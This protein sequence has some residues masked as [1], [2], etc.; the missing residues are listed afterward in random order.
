M[1]ICETPAS[2]LKR[3]SDAKGRSQQTNSWTP[4][5]QRLPGPLWR[6]S[7]RQQRQRSILG[8]RLHWK[9]DDCER[10]RA[11]SVGSWGEM[12]IRRRWRAAL[13]AEMQMRSSAFQ[14]CTRICRAWWRRSSCSSADGL[15][16]KFGGGWRSVVHACWLLALRCPK[17]WN[18]PGLGTTLG[19][20][21]VASIMPLV[22]S[23]WWVKC[24]STEGSR[25][26]QNGWRCALFTCEIH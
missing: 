14:G 1:S 5:P 12:L 2:A 24:W 21:C 6:G 8:R 17:A 9:F 11:A 3:L 19:T 22:F 15:E 20:R 7:M 13:T 18:R 26:I 25:M 16:V 4:G 23:K 10:G